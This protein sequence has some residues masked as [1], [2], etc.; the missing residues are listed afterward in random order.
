[1]T[2]EHLRLSVDLTLAGGT[3]PAIVLSCLLETI[4]DLISSLE[5]HG[6]YAN[7]TEAEETACVQV[8]AWD[9]NPDDPKDAYIAYIESSLV[10][11]QENG[12]QPLSFEEFIDRW[13]W[14]GFQP[15]SFEE[16][17]DR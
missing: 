4:P 12:F 14:H 16:F 9:C 8:D 7:Q 13:R 15:L 1:M 11:I 5:S 10:D 2:T 6:V 3:D 17:I